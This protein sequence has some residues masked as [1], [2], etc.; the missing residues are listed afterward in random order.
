MIEGE[1]NVC[2]VSS[3]SEMLA[4]NLGAVVRC[5][6]RDR[7]PRLLLS[8]TCSGHKLQAMTVLSA[9]AG[10]VIQ[11]PDPRLRRLKPLAM[12]LKPLATG[13][14]KHKFHKQS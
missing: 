4:A 14:I 9:I 7:P 3:E 6:C 5:R 2:K 12:N 1:C 8:L 10:A 11:A 13:N